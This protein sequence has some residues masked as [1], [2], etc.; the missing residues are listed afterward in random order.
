M[1]DF[2]SILDEIPTYERF[3]AIDEL[4]AKITA[5]VT[6]HKGRLEQVELGFSTLGEP[7]SCIRV[8]EGRFNA[9][10]HGFPNC[11]EP[12]GGNLLECLARALAEHDDVI[13]E[14]DYTWYLIGCSDPDGARLNNGFQKGPI[15]PL[16]FTLNY[17]RTPVS[18]TPESCFPFRFGSLNFNSPVP[19]TQALMK[20]MDRIEFHF[21]S[22]LHM[23]KWGGVTYE[24]PH[25]CPELYVHLWE[26]ARRF[27][28]FLR[29][30]PGT[31][32]APG[33]MKADYL[34]PARGYIKHLA[35][36]ETNIEP[37]KGCYIYEYGKMLNPHMFMMIPECCIWYD[38]RMWNDTPTDGTLGDSLRYAHD[39]ATASDNFVLDAWKSALPFLKTRTQ[40]KEMIKENMAPLINKYTNVSNPPF[41]FNSKVHARKA[42]MAEKIGI[43]GRE[44]LY[45][46]F[47]LGGLIRTIDAEL[48]SSRGSMLEKIR[49]ETLVKLKEYD[50]HL[51]TV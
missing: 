35:R 6:E 50:R 2:N 23:M 10:I 26:S 38:P 27:N 45:I 25:A 47:D 8:G 31:T 11:E 9:L 5:L 44:D 4:N 12:Y 29:K 51:H 7:I 42:T 43:E 48:K 39:R 22:S 37:I 16:N 3:Y 40:F 33:I 28:V 15:T 46:M 21:V 34:T 19:E 30:R 20:L 41:I 36:G 17:Y 1:P 49:E 14:L 24:V 13:K 18:K 32:I